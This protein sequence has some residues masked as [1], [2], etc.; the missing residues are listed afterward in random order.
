MIVRHR[1][2]AAWALAAI[3]ALTTANLTVTAIAFHSER[4]SLIDIQD[5]LGARL[6]QM[7]NADLTV[8]SAAG[9]GAT[10]SVNGNDAVGQINLTTGEN[11]GTGSLIHVTFTT[12]YKV[13]P[14]AYVTPED[15]PPPADWY[16][17]IDWNGFDIWV[18]TPPKPETNYPFNYLV[19]ARPWSMYLNAEGKPVNADGTPSQY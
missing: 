12:P 4:G 3:I 18:S 6:P 17:T 13:Q 5:T 11:P 16:V 1:K 10:G 2:P 7:V 8:Q 15:A 19:V 14:F 9:K